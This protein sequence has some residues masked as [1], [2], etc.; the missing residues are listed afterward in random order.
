MT[1]PLNKPYTPPPRPELPHEPIIPWGPGMCRIANLEWPMEAALMIHD[2]G[3]DDTTIACIEIKSLDV[4]AWQHNGIDV[5]TTVGVE[6]TRHDAY[7]LMV[8]LA[9][10]LTKGTI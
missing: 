3:G 2:I 8:A 7:N 9:G 4:E 5:S 6:I 10:I 1:D